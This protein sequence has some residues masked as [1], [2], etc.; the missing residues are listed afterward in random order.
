MAVSPAATGAIDMVDRLSPERR[1]WLMSRIGGK[2][3]R[4]EVLVRSMLHRLGYR[5]SLHRRDLPGTPD[6]VLPARGAVVFV[7]GCF[8]HGHACKR[9]R[10][11]KS[12]IDY[13]TAKIDA[14]RLRD[15]R[16]RRQLVSLGWKVVVVWEC[17]LKNPDK[18]ESKFLRLI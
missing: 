9:S 7:N 6:I 8:W 1:S 12:R 16:K 18:L 11:P 3:T 2:N 15:A 17:E 4:P 10:M 13:W 5:F 14:N